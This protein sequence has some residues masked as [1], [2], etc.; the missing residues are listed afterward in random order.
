MLFKP[1]WPNVKKELPPKPN[2]WSCHPM[3]QQLQGSV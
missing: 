2:N 1:T 3:W